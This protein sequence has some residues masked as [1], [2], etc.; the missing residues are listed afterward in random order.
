MMVT[1]IEHLVLL[2]LHRMNV[3]VPGQPGQDP[4]EPFHWWWA[5]IATMVLYC[6]L[7]VIFGKRYGLI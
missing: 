7:A 5:L 3:H 2:S 6:I 4:D 1:N